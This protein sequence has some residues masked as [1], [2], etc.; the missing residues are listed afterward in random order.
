VALD[1]G[2]AYLGI[3]GEVVAVA[4]TDG[5]VRWR[6]RVATTGEVGTPTVADGV[7][8]VA[9]GLD[10]DP[11]DLGVAT[12][13]AGTGAPGWRY[14]SPTQAQLYTPA[15]AGGRA[16]VVGHDRALVALDAA[17]GLVEWTVTRS[18]GL[19]ALPAVVDDAVFI[20]GND[21]DAEAV[22][23]ATGEVRWGVPVE[24]VPFAP[25][26][27]DGCLLVGTGLGLLYSICGS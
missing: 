13:D 7:V 22:D 27:V 23:A 1:D 17:T 11:P 9:T 2:L 15:V 18:V 12:L 5:A 3:G 21:G 4:A 25:A 16:F 20:V 14:V 6:R 10:G 8:F 26:V 19:E 24:G